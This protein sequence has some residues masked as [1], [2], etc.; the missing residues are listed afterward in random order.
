MSITRGKNNSVNNLQS[1]QHKKQ[2]QQSEVVK[3]DV[4]DIVETEGG[5]LGLNELF[6][7]C[8][9]LINKHADSK[10][11]KIS[12]MD[13]CNMVNAIRPHSVYRNEDIVLVATPYS[14]VI[15]SPEGEQQININNSMLTTILTMVSTGVNEQTINKFSTALECLHYEFNDNL[16]SNNQPY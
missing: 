14:L 9:L 13:V 10:I 8:S 12:I 4:T 1:L 7:D 5:D 15:S 6:A 16:H 11:M 2:V 3:N